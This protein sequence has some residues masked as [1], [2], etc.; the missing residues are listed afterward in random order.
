MK[1]VLALGLAVLMALALCACGGEEPAVTADPNAGRYLCTSVLLEG[2]ELGAD[3]EYLE[4]QNG[5]VC[6]FFFYETPADGTWSL[7]GEALTITVPYSDMELNAAG[8]LKDGVIT[9]TVP[10]MGDAT[11]TFQMEG[12]ITE[13]AET[14]TEEAPA[15]ETPAE[16]PA[17]ETPAE[18]APAGE[19]PA[20][21]A[22]D[23]G[24]A[25]AGEAQEAV[26]Q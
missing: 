18:E 15:E 6:T 3:G 13:T 21:E 4:L 7:D 9:M 12:T 16:A 14:V 20:P 2:M 25:P 19:T 22:A 23:A 1:K 11:L 17:E 24:E 26:P 8:T 10:E 5:G